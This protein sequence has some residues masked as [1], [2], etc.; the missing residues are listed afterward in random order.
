V[1]E[2]RL[3]AAIIWAFITALYASAA[4]FLPADQGPF[5]SMRRRPQEKCNNA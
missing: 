5:S 3:E 1:S 2:V 4:N